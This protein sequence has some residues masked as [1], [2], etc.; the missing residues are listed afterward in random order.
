MKKKT[1]LCET[2]SGSRKELATTLINPDESASC[3]D[4]GLTKETA[5]PQDSV[6]DGKLGFLP[7]DHL[8]IKVNTMMVSNL[9][10]CHFTSFPCL[11]CNN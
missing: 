7:G 3:S 10:Q 11:V 6:N 4:D 2:V 1:W 5:A 9:R 8:T